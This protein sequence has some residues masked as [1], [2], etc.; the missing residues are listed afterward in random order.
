MSVGSL[1]AGWMMHRTGKYKMIN[2]IF[3]L[4]PFI[5]TVLIYR[6]RED[7]GPIQSWLSIVSFFPFAFLCLYDDGIDSSWVWKCS[8]V[9]DD[10]ECV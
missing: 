1:F 10:V 9:A 5:A 7:S 6:M 8:C 4:F 2:L 3:G